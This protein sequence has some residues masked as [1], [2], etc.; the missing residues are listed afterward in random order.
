MTSSTSSSYSGGPVANSASKTESRDLLESAEEVKA[1]F[2]DP[3]VQG[4]EGAHS[5]M[6]PNLPLQ[7][8]LDLGSEYDSRP[9]SEL[10]DVESRP[11]SGARIES[12]TSST[13]HLFFTSV[14]SKAR[15]YSIDDTVSDNLRVIEPFARPKSPMPQASMSGSDSPKL[16]STDFEDQKL[17]ISLSGPADPPTTTMMENSESFEADMAFSKHFTQVFDEAEFESN[18]TN[19]TDGKAAAGHTDLTP[20][21]IGDSVSDSL[22]TSTGQENTME[23]G[24]PKAIACKPLFDQDD[25]LVGSPPMVSRPL[26]VKYWPPVDNLDQDLDTFGPVD[27]QSITRSES[28]DNSES[29]LDL[30]NDLMEKEVEDG[31]KWLENQFEGAQQQHEE[32]S[33]FTYGQPLDQILEEEEDRYSHSSEDIKELQRFKES[34]SSTPDFDQIVTKRSHL[35]RSGEQDD[36]SMGS[37]TEF[38]RLEREVALGSVSGSGSHGSLGSNDSLEV[39]HTAQTADKPKSQLVSKVILS[40]SGTGDDVSV[41]SYSSLKSFELMEQAC[42]E[43]ELIEKKAKQQEEVLSEIEEG[44]ESQESE[45]AETISEFGEDDRS[46]QDYEDRLFEIDSIIKQAQD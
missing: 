22:E 6:G 24:H 33:Q 45:S 28:D 26:G 37:L 40:K 31:K 12:R 39:G 23:S 46:E 2:Q 30:D 25:L 19:K 44:H 7:A 38:E 8:S 27:K 5:A 15:S 14:Q 9:N 43:A 41:D 4:F 32:Y 11:H 34:L 10:K 21:S 18:E 20:D 36:L 35:S 42:K 16:S 17:R 1:D 13:E 29:R 3:R